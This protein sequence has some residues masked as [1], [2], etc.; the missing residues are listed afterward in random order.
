MD[1]NKNLEIDPSEPWDSL[2]VTLTDS[3]RATLV[4][5]THDTVPPRI[6]DV[7]VLDSLRLGVTF[8][9]PVDPTQTLGVTNFAVIAPDSSRVP[10]V[11]AGP[12]VKDTATPLNPAAGANPPSGANPVTGANP[13]TRANPLSRGR[14]PNPAR[15][16]TSQVIKPVMPRPLPITEVV[17]K[18]VRPLTPKLVYHV[19]A[20]GIRG[21]T[22][23]IGDSERSYTAPAPAPPPAAKPGAV[24]PSAKPV[25]VPPPTPPAVKK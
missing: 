17:I 7:K 11:S 24:P 5:F 18:L 25:A 4:L 22:G 21:L 10:I 2:G 19:R 16:D 8:D 23:R 9:K 13:A 20:I 14:V 12:P 3:A 15:R 6:G 1:R